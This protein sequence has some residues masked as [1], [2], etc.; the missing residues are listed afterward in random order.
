MIQ[1]RLS[2]MTVEELAVLSK[3]DWRRL[4]DE[5]RAAGTR[6]DAV[7]AWLDRLEKNPPLSRDADV[8]ALVRE[9]RR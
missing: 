3:E 4:V 7:L 2:R 1:E 6:D 5:I 8:V 9:G